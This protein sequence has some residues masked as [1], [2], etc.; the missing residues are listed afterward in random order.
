MK[1]IKALLF[2][3]NLLFVP[4]AYAQNFDTKSLDKFWALTELL[5]QD[6]PIS[7]SLW[8]DFYNQ[9][10]NKIWFEAARGLDKNYP[11][12]YRKCMEI[13]YMPSKKAVLN[14][15][16]KNINAR[17]LDTIFVKGLYEEYFLQEKE[18]KTYYDKVL[19]SAY[20]DSAYVRALRVLPKNFIKPQKHLD[21]LNLY[22][23]GIEGS[24]MAGRKGI[25]FGMSGLYQIDKGQ[26]A[27][28][29]AHELHHYLRPSQLKDSIKSADEFAVYGLEDC[30]NEGSADL[31][32]VPYNIN[33]PDFARLK[34]FELEGSE[35]I[36]K[37]FD[38]WLKT[39][40][41]TKGKTTHTHDEVNELFKYSGGHNPGY[42]MAEVIERNGFLDDLREHIGD[43]F[44][45]L[46]LYDK[47]TKR[48]KN[49]PF[50]FSKESL[51]F[52]KQLRKIYVK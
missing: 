38:A 42:Y 32:N 47:A 27:A 6:K 39:A 2:V 11:E 5:K 44:Y 40:Y 17:G 50:T 31:L 21:T 16:L 24:A 29:A 52:A 15:F 10:A 1:N 46:I 28:L 33:N 36:L 25:F 22:I 35:T 18:I 8:T 49:T 51:L 41:L 45:F 3:A 43:P 48:D 26:F 19:K 4:H 37:T 20:M 7:D 12:S 30:L 23:H 13:V 14:G 9:K 34:I